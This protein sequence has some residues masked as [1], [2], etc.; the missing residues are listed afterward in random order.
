M[1]ISGIAGSKL[2]RF[3]PPRGLAGMQ[4]LPRLFRSIRG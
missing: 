1:A 2:P 3:V 4:Q